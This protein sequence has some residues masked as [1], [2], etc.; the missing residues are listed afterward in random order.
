MELPTPWAKGEKTV[1]E[2]L[3]AS[4]VTDENLDETFRLLDKRHDNIYRFVMGYS[5]YILSEHDYGCGIPLTM[6][7]VHTL[8]YIDDHPDATITEIA[9]I[10][11]KTKSAISQIVSRLERQ[12]LLTKER[13]PDNARIVKLVPTELGHKVSRAHKLYDVRD[14]ARTN[15]DLRQECSS[16]EI[17]AFYKVLEVFNRVM[18][19]EFETLAPRRRASAAK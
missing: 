13:Q 15:E 14:I 6:I 12:G 19:K 16:E 4:G 10:W 3:I 17:D 7:E 5:N 9:R 11:H 8:T 18:E 2:L 1:D